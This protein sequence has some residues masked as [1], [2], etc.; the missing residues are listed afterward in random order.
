MIVRWTYRHCEAQKASASAYWQE[1]LPRLERALSRFGSDRC[2]LDMILYFHHVHKRWELRASLYLPTGLIVS[3]EEGA[4]LHS[5][6]DK[7]ADELVRQIHRHK[8]KVRKEHL[9]RRRQRQLQH[10]TAA[11]VSL[12][13][14]Y[15]VR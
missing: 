6:L 4:E 13:S 8:A 11:A 10:E 7:A 5:V 3:N 14:D 1:K 9:F 15:E 2:R 12:Q